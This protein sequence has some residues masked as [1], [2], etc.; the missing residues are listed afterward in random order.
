M[1]RGIGGLLLGSVE[2]SGYGGVPHTRTLSSQGIGGFLILGYQKSSA[3]YTLT[4][5]L[6]V[7]GEFPSTNITFRSWVRVWWVGDDFWYSSMR[8]SPTTPSPSELSK[9]SNI[10]K[11]SELSN[12]LAT[13]P[14]HPKMKKKVALPLLA[15]VLVGVI[16]SHI[17]FKP[18]DHS[19]LMVVDGIE[20][21][22]LGKLKNQWL[23]HTQNCKDVSQLQ[24]GSA[25]FKAI[26]N[27]IQSYSP[28]QSQSAQ[29]ASMW[30]LGNWTL[31]EVEF[32][33]LLPAVVTL[34]TD[35]NEP[36]IVPH[37]IWSGLTKP[38]MTAPLIR[39]YLTKQV[40][41]IPSTLLNCFVP[42]SKSFN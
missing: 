8:N 18:A 25:N 16:A 38:W 37:G 34:Q 24:E 5:Q 11:P 19:Y 21:D 27:T 7:C 40:P 20:I 15:I 3:P 39:T 32:E 33:A 42:R 26:Q 9:I 35:N 29:I 30:S 13:R 6:W 36:K 10:S 4:T 14:Q 17:S 41:E 31:A 28:P 23:T 22:V 1:A 2:S 12:N